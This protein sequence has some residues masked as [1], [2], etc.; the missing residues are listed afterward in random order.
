MFVLRNGQTHSNQNNMSQ[1]K[2]TIEE[3]SL[4]PGIQPISR[5]KLAR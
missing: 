4:V 3:A 5:L 1:P 2:L